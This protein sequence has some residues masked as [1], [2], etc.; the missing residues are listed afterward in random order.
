MRKISTVAAILYTMSYTLP[1]FSADLPKEGRYD[2]TN[3]WSGT[4][5]QIE[6]SATY[7]ARSVEF[8]GSVRS[9]P[10]GG[11]F[12]NSSFRCVGM[13]ESFNGK[14]SGRNVCEAI[15]RDGDKRLAVFSFGSDGKTT[16]ENIAGTGKYDGM[17]IDGTI[18][19]LGPFPVVKPGMFQGCNHQTGTYK[20]K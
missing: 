6:F 14:T 15:D 13:N 3:C 7:T 2:T 5:N 1:A 11:M 18:E 20:M 17:I 12:D 10:P 8:T 19:L 16:R 4:V 9:N